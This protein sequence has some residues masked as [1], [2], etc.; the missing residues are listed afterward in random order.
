MILYEILIIS[1]VKCCVDEGV[2]LG[3]VVPGE[4]DGDLLYFLNDLA[5][6]LILGS[7]GLLVLVQV[8]PDDDLLYYIVVLVAL[9]VSSHPLVELLL[10]LFI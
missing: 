8:D 10:Q 4:F 7:Q 1:T 9:P 2:P 3:G 5:E 6:L